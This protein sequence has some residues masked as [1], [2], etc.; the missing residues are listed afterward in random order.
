GFNQLVR[1]E[2]TAESEHRWFEISQHFLSVPGEQAREMR[3]IAA[4]A[5]WRSGQREPALQEW[6]RLGSAP[7]ALAARILIGEIQPSQV[8]F[9]KLRAASW[10]EA[11]VRL[12]AA[13]HS[14][15]PPDP[16][17]PADAK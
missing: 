14:L 4:V 3:A 9:S 8:D 2:L 5:V 16:L 6:R 11:L 17:R 1:D 13:R 12:A 15:T 10:E 7:S